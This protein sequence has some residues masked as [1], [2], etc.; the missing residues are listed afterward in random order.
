MAG[1]PAAFVNSEEET[2]TQGW[3]GNKREGAWVPDALEHP[4]C[5]GL[6]LSRLLL[7]NK[8][9]SILFK[10]LLFWISCPLQPKASTNWES[11]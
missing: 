9:T 5:S 11:S 6:T 4:T 7:H 2:M 10:L 1:A 3:Q 8:E